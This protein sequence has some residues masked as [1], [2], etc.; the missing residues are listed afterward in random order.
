MTSILNGIFLFCEDKVRNTRTLLS[1]VAVRPDRSS[2]SVSSDVNGS[3]GSPKW[4]AVAA[5]LPS[6]RSKQNQHHVGCILSQQTAVTDI[7][8][9]YWF[10]HQNYSREADQMEM[11]CRVPWHDQWQSASSTLVKIMYQLEPNQQAVSN[12]SVLHTSCEW[13]CSLYHVSVFMC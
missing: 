5:G 10:K 9:V 2:V 1:S 7:I 4:V 12:Y 13:A 6:D 11:S 8:P 3:S